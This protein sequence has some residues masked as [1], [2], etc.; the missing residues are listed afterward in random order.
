MEQFQDVE[1]VSD[2]KIIS[3]HKLLLALHSEYFRT[4]FSM[5]M[6]RFTEVD[7]NQVEIV[8]IGPKTMK[9]VKKFL[10]TGKIEEVT[11]DDGI[12][13]L[14]A[15]TFFMIS[16]EFGILEDLIKPYEND[17][18]E[19]ERE[20]LVQY[21]IITQILSRRAERIQ[22]SLDNSTGDLS[23]LSD[24]ELNMAADLVT[25]GYLSEFGMNTLATKIK[26]SWS[27]WSDHPS[28][29]E[30]RCAAALAATGHLTEVKNMKLRD[31]EV[32]SSENM[33][34][35]A[36]MVSDRVSLTGVTGDV[37]P[38]LSSLSC[39]WLWISNMELDQTA[40]C[41]GVRD[42]VVLR[43][44][45]GDVGPLL[46]SLTCSQ[47]R[48]FNMELDQ[49]ATS[50][51]VQGLQ[52]GVEV[53]WLCDGVRLHLQTLVEYDG[54]GRCVEVRCEDDT[55]DT[56]REGGTWAG[57]INWNVATIDGDVVMWRPDD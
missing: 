30:V 23:D 21:R 32:P 26:S 7:R 56:Y 28:V 9:T 51:L 6:N 43:N 47:L 46:S 29:A 42:S 11:R 31:M 37:G 40:S 25:T 8:C 16:D 55:A 4:F 14:E 19:Y 49:A 50:G 36:R 18:D 38:L 2:G 52:L 3:C 20:L 33:L 53:L 54:R 41:S 44:V 34:S 15:F 22:S 5:D 45:T 27:N 13:L 12:S 35:L 48:I 10:Y 1:L 39:E 24:H 17:L 57:R